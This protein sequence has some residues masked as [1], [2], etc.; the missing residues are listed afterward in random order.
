MTTALSLSFA[1][2]GSFIWSLR[3]PAMKGWNL[4]ENKW[5]TPFVYFI[6]GGAPRAHEFLAEKLPITDL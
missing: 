1:V 6:P 2:G 3:V 4:A 5:L